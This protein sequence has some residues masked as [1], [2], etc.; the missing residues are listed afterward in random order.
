ML[1]NPHITHR[2]FPCA[3]RNYKQVCRMSFLLS[4][5]NLIENEQFNS[6]LVLPDFNREKQT[7]HISECQLS[8]N[9][10]TTS[11]QQLPGA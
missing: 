6:S 7:H 10:I 5:L 3:E 8:A 11:P 2:V 1:T 9:G 4:N